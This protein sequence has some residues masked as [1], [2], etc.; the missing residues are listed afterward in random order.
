MLSVVPGQRV[1]QRF[2][3]RGGQQSWLCRR[4][5]GHRERMPA[6]AA[7]RLIYVAT[8]DWHFLSHCLAMARA[9]RAAGFEGHVAANGTEA[10]ATIRGGGFILH[11]VRFGPGRLS[12]LRTL[13]TL[14]TLRPL[15][16]R[17][18]PATPPHVAL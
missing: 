10:A 7:P 4:S 9:A 12:P 16:R 13:R 14:A 18:D 2:R 15:Y 1:A 6:R 11:A 5:G 17:V 8:E 3:S